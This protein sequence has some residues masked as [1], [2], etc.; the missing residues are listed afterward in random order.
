MAWLIRDYRELLPF[1]SGNCSNSTEFQDL[2]P[3]WYDDQLCD[4]LIT[5]TLEPTTKLQT[6][7]ETTSESEPSTIS[8]SATSTSDRTSTT[9]TA[10]Q[11]TTSTGTGTT[12]TQSPDLP[13]EI[14]Y[15][16]FFY[17]LYGVLGGIA[18]ILIFGFIFL[19]YKSVIP[20]LLFNL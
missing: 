2:N 15:D 11:N 3:S 7:F 1:V 14:N 13:T 8:E 5:T 9:V 17:I 10:G 12:D 18:L 19:D 20:S 4:S 16:I 6:T